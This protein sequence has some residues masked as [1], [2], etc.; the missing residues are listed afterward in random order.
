MVRLPFTGPVANKQER[1]VL[2]TGAGSGIGRAIALRQAAAGDIVIATDIDLAAAQQTAKLAQGACEAYALD[3]TD[4]AQGQQVADTVIARF[5]V[6]DILV[7]N[8]GI[9][10][11]GAFLDQTPQ[12]W[13]K[14]MAINVHGVVHGS[15][16]IGAKMVERGQPGHIVVIASGAAWTPNRVAPSYSASKAAAL[17]VAESLRTELAPKNI[18][19][20]AVCPGVTRTQ[21]AANATL[22]NSGTPATEEFRA[23]IA[24]AQ[25]RFAFATPDMVARAVQRAI[26]YNL[27][28]VP[29][30]FD[31]TLAFV[32]HR[33]SPGL[34]RWICSIPTMKLAESTMRMAVDRMP[35]SI[36]FHRE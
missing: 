19:V 25:A 30:N 22:V 18:G 29:V 4:P 33:V 27:A 35:A 23:H 32:L 28:I 9:A 21:L 36:A 20:S 17:M 16:I 8:A 26:R 14:I 31:A 7:N 24:D 34:M 15:T 13:E 12:D 6:P 3:V 5:G 1:L 10:L 11:G 2:V